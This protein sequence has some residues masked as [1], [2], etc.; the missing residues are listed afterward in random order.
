MWY[1]DWD[2]DIINQYEV[3][4]M[5]LSW[6]KEPKEYYEKQMGTQGSETTE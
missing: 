3:D 4:F 1:E 5:F 2:F 6:F